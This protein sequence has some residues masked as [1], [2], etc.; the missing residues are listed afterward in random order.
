[1]KTLKK[2]APALVLLLVVS[3]A[4][5]QNNIDDYNRRL[6]ERHE[7]IRIKS[8]ELMKGSTENRNVYSSEMERSIVAARRQHLEMH[9]RLSSQQL[10]MTQ[11]Y[12]EA[13]GKYHNNMIASN[14]SLKAELSKPQPNETLVKQYSGQIN[15]SAVEAEQQHEKMISTMGTK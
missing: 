12:N 14:N 9:N 15:Q 10:S 1:M 7:A 6:A 11:P 5:A 3:F 8:E 2:L 4:N 13:I